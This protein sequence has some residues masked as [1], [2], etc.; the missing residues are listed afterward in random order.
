[1]CRVLRRRGQEGH[2]LHGRR[3]T[4]ELPVPVDDGAGVWFCNIICDCMCRCADVW[5]HGMWVG[6]CVLPTPGSP[7]SSL[8]APSLTHARAEAQPGRRALRARRQALPD[9]PVA[10]ALPA[11]WRAANWRAAPTGPD[12]TPAP[13]SRPPSPLDR[14]SPS[15]NWRAASSHPAGLGWRRAPP[16]RP[17][18]SLPPNRGHLPRA[19]ASVPTSRTTPNELRV[20]SGT[21]EMNESYELR[22]E[23]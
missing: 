22:V 17:P 8:L 9:G 23:S 16:L 19:T 11:N 1:M 10:V 3:P 5:C 15:A 21:N 20:E 4:G 7:V 2:G 14:P 13:A 18:P 12:S 6:E